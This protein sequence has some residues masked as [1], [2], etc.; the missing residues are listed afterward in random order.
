VQEIALSER[1]FKC[2]RCG[3]SKDRDLNASINILKRA[4]EGQSGSHASGDGIR[5]SHMKAVVEER[6]T[7][8]GV[9]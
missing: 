3:M 7:T 4:T 6:G 8:F 5:P 9:S 2:E 1:T